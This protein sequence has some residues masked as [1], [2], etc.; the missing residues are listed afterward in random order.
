M[1][2]KLSEHLLYSNPNFESP[3]ET[4]QKS[5]TIKFNTKTLITWIIEVGKKINTIRGIE[6]SGYSDQ[7][8]TINTT[9][10]Q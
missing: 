4:Q 10:R 8:L 5:E 2:K 9:Q 7:T 6:E 3:V 1:L